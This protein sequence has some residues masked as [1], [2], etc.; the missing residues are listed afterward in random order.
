MN[1]EDQTPL[2]D[3]LVSTLAVIEAQPLEA[4]A[5]AYVQLHEHLRERLEGGDVPAQV[6]G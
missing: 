2:D 1:T 4:R 3:A 6:A 5:A